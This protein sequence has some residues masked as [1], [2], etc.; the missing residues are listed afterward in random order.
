MLAMK[1][2]ALLAELAAKAWED[3]ST[4][5]A[6]RSRATLLVNVIPAIQHAAL[7]QFG[8]GWE[9]LLGIGIAWQS[10]RRSNSH[11]CKSRFCLMRY[12]ATPPIS[13]ITTT[14]PTTRIF[15]RSRS[16]FI[17]GDRICA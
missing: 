4:A 10:I 5:L 17:A 16:S 13:K 8:G 14:I 1:L 15:V 9:S 7:Y 2:S 11:F 3:N 12:I 6:A